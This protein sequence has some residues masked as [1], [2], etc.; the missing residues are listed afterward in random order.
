L[1]SGGSSRD[2][3]IL[4]KFF[5]QVDFGVVSKV[6]F[7]VV[8]QVDSRG[9]QRMDLEAGRFFRLDS[10]SLSRLDFVG[11]QGWISL[12]FQVGFGFVKAPYII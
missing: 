2:G 10:F 9:L 8:S 4:A 7:K 1:D 12:V 11:L 6:D 5:S 3:W